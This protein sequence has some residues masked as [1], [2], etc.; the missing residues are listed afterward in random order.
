VPEEEV[1]PAAPRVE[2]AAASEEVPAAKPVKVLM[3]IAPDNFRDEEL[4]EPR[5]ILQQHGATVVI[6][7]T[8]RREYTGMKGM[9]V[10][11]DLTLKQV[12]V[13]DYGAIVFI[14][15]VGAKTYWNHPTA[16]QIAKDTVRLK[17]VLGA[18]CIAPVILAN[19]GVLKGKRAT[20]WSSEAGRLRAKGAIY[21]GASVEVDGRIITGNGP[22]AAVKFGHALA[23]TLGL[24]KE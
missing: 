3:I 16:L 20:V 5:R 6:A 24:E 14:G 15:G 9:K 18:I 10:T 7:S 1:Q 22:E 2:E 13:A 11:P 12:N 21:T 17:K 23:R 8:A 4:R 19:A